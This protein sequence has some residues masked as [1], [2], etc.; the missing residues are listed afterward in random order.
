MVE[1]L[2]QSNP[3]PAPVTLYAEAIL[4][5]QGGE[6]THG[7]LV[8]AADGAGNIA[9]STCSGSSSSSSGNSAGSGGGSGGSR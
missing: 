3:G 6:Q 8:V 5:G 9:S 2:R 4:R 7:V 1:A